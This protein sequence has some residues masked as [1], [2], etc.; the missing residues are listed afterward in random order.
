MPKI[1]VDADA[2]PVKQET[3]R[4]AV[5]YGMQPIF[6]ACSW[7]RLPELASPRMVVVESG[8]DA[9][10]DWIAEQVA[11]GDIVVTADVPLAARCIEKGAAALRPNGRIFSEDNIGDALATRNLL[12]DLRSGGEVLGGPPPFAKTDRSRFLQGHPCSSSP[13]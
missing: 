12:A 11:E 8:F 7:M 6:V 3:C 2:C 13:D 1:Y 9:A 10:D 5:R 4:V